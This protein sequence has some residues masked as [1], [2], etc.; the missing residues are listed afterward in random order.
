MKLTVNGKPLGPARAAG[1]FVID[2]TWEN[3][4]EIH[5]TLPMKLHTHPMPD[6]QTLQAI[7]YGPLVLAGNLGRD[8][9]T[10][11]MRQGGDNPPDMPAP[12]PAPE[13]VADAPDPQS[14]L[15]MPNKTVLAFETKGQTRNISMM[16]F[17]RI[18]D[19]RYGVYWRVKPKQS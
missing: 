7:M 18:S 14:W 11:A 19:Q 2:R 6:D 1:Y 15:D 4:D 5:A 3:G 9:L 10:E 8:G 12:P 17:S 16:P 13:F